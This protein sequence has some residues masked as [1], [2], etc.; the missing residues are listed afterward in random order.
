MAEQLTKEIL[1]FESDYIWVHENFDALVKKYAEQWIAVKEHQVIATAPEF[2]TLL[3][4]LSD[5]AHICIEFVTQEP[6]EMVL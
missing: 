2:L 4:K 6:L 3:D 5:P 1:A